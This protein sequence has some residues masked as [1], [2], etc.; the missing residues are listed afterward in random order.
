MIVDKATGPEL[1]Y[2]KQS[3]KKSG[4]LTLSDNSGRAIIRKKK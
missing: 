3:I 4:K 1:E 2:R